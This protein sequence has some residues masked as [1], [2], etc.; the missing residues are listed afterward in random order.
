MSALREL[1]D[2]LAPPIVAPG[3]VAHFSARPVPGCEAHRIGKDPGGNPCLL[4]Y[5]GGGV[6]QAVPPPIV[7]SHLAVQHDV[8]CRIS[9]P[10]QPPEESTFTLIRCLSGD[11]ALVAKFLDVMEVVIRT[12]GRAPTADR[13][14]HAVE[15]L[16]EL[17]RSLDR[18][19]RKSVQG[20]WAELFLI[21]RAEDPGRLAAAWHRIPG[22][23]FDFS[24]GGDRVEVKAASGGTRQHYFALT[25]VHP[26]HGVRV[27]VA[28]LFV[29]A[30]SGGTPVKG[31]LV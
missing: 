22:E 8:L 4:L 24:E 29:E 9:R 15:E 26:P 11:A 19:P 1:F 18:P 14:R 27:L 12:V 30:L 2:S 31:L 16:A 17:F 10:P 5:V 20:V 28:S 7:L 3:N 6:G 13:V 25:Q 23:A 21:A